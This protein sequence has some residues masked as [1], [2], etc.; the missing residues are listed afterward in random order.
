[1]G[2]E[3]CNVSHDVGYT[4]NKARMNKQPASDKVRSK[5][6]LGVTR[7]TQVREGPRNPP[8]VPSFAGG[9]IVQ[10]LGGSIVQLLWTEEK[11]GE[12]FT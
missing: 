2:E 7:L 1:M 3:N 8:E 11:P 10:L 9:S 6:A 12:L 4:I 5:T